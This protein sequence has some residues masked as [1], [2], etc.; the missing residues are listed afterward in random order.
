MAN[1]SK[2]LSLIGGADR[3]VD[4]SAASIVLELGGSGLQMN[5]STSGHVVIAASAITSTYSM[6]WPAAQAVSSGYVLTNDGTGVLSWS[7]AAATGANTALSNL[8]SVAINLS[9]LP[10]ADNS[11]NLGSAAKSW[12]SANIHSLDD[13]SSAISID[14]YGRA[15]EDA[16]AAT[17][18][19]WSASGV[20]FNQLT[21]STVPYLDSGSILTSSAV[22]PTELGYVSGVTSAIQT[23]LNAKQSTALTT[24]HIL[25]G[26]G[27]VATDVAM[28]G[29]ASIVASGAVTLSN[30]AVIAKV[31][32][33]YTS[34]AGTI[35]AADSIL[36]AI[37]KL[38]GN[39]ALKLVAANNLTDVGSKSA[40]FNN[41]SPITTKGDLI[42]GDGS[43]FSQRLAVGSNGQVLTADSTQ[44]LGVKWGSASAGTV[45][46]V[47]FADGSSTPIYSVSGSPVTSSGTLTITLA[48][49]SANSVFAGPTSGGAAQ[50][51]FRSLVSSDIPSLSAIYLPL[52]GGT[53]S[54][55]INLG[56][57]TPT[58]SGTPVNPNDLVN[59][60]YVDNFINAT[61]WKTAVHVASTANIDLSVAADPN[62]ID[63]VT[64]SD[65]DQILLKN[66]IAPAENGIY[67]A[68]TA[69]DPTTW[70]RASDMNTWAQVPA[71]AVFVQSG[72]LNADLGFVCTSQPGGTLGTTAITFVQFSS[73]GSYSADGVTLQ[74]ISGVFSVKNGGI[75]NAQ[76]SASAAIDFSKLAALPSAEILVGNGSNVATAV[77]VSG[78]ISL[79]NAGVTAITATSNGTLATLSALTTASSLASVGTITSGTWNG[80][81]IAINHGGTGQTSASAAFAALSPLTTTGDIIYEN[82]TPAPARLPIGSTGQVLTVVGGLPAWAPQSVS[83]SSIALTQNHILVGNASNLAADVA[84]SGDVAI[85][86]SGATTIQ[87]GAVTASKL[88]TVTDGVTLDQSGAGSTLEIK[89]AG[90]SAT[91]LATGAFDQVTITGGAGTAASVASSPSVKESMVAGEA[92]AATTLFAVR[93]AKA[94]DAGFVAGRVY[95]ADNDTTSADNFYVIGL[96]YSAGSVST[97]GAIV[98]TKMG[99]INVP[100]HGFTPGAPLF[101]GSS[102]AV[103]ATAPSASLSAVERVGIVRDANN[104]EVQIAQI[105]VN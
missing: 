96:A 47:A 88:G 2:F 56:G 20:E 64:I 93:F 69:T 61:S 76:I 67:V 30:A 17:Q 8:A 70:T 15:L 59:K 89:A 78:D 72:T 103:T 71:A 87:A 65:G 27:G 41:I 52:S 54:G 55:A 32:T 101:L 25:V 33:G 18:L 28:S 4:L 86:A 80:T 81:T 85:I 68:V 9:L 58:N 12:A 26:S 62:P 21:P 48:T 31:L 66:Q 60:S 77:A 49:Q 102:G 14:V 36:S 74:L 92:F 19:S 7:P 99:L 94:A 3:T 98:A 51:T 84:M 90:V 50:P 82:V 42:A 39:D 29:E 73:A 44:T 45:T 75:A 104:I 100:S 105:G 95:K 37:Q 97:G 57:F 43:G 11:I 53:M 23:Q 24:N 22:T 35:S 16:S 13:A 79:S 6:V 83:P 5:G 63:G 34:G 38:N 1:F 10:G 40:S 46:S 91:Q